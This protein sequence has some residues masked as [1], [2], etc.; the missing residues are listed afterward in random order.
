MKHK[1]IG[2]D[3]LAFAISPHMADFHRLR[4]TTDN[5]SAE[6]DKTTYVEN[7]APHRLPLGFAQKSARAVGRI[8]A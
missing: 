2:R 3:G 7:P 8:F 6:S 1:Q 4:S 5:F